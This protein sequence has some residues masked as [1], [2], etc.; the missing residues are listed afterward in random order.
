M[1]FVNIAVCEQSRAGTLAR[2]ELRRMNNLRRS[3]IAVAAVAFGF[4]LATVPATA[5]AQ[6]AKGGPATPK[7]TADGKP[8]LNG[9]WQAFTTAAWNIQDHIGQLG[10]PP[11]LGI[12]EGNDIPYQ[13]S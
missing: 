13:P 11:G 6:N 4:C 7:R 9:V 8:D 5:Q 12:V 3:M 2:F 1:R 10:V